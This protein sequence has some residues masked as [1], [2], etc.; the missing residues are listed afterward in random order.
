MTRGSDALSVFDAV[1]GGN[2]RMVHRRQ[3]ACLALE[4]LHA[5]GV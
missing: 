5:S 2:V 1:D 4:A 3:D